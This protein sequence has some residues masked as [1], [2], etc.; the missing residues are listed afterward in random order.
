MSVS[1]PARLWSALRAALVLGVFA[2]AMP[3]AAMEASTNKSD[4]GSVE[5]TGAKTDIV[6]AAAHNVHVA[7]TSSDDV[8]VAGHDLRFDAGSADHVFAAG[9]TI[10][11]TG[12]NARAFL[13]AGHDITF[14]TGSAAS[15]VI[16]FGNN[17]TLNP[18][19]K[20]G[21]S[22]VVFGQDVHLQSPVGRDLTIGGGTVTIDSAITGNVRAQGRH[23]IIGPN[24]RIGGDLSYRAT[25]K[26]EI[27]PTAVITGKKVVLPAD[28]N[29][30]TWGETRHGH[31]VMAG[32]GM[33]HRIMHDVMG[34]L[35][36][37]VLSLVLTAVFPLLMARAGGMLTR[38]PLLAAG[39]GLMVLIVGPVLSILAMVTIIGLSLAFAMWAL[40]WAALLIGFVGAAA[41]IAALAGRYGKNDAPPKLGTQ[42]LWT[43]LGA[44]VI[45]ALGATPYIGFWV[46]LVACVLGTGAVSA[47]A[48]SLMAKGA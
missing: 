1:K 34:A 39:V 8:F 32:G 25:D 29:S 11:V 6:F 16:A 44:I 46:W 31:M 4:N 35:G 41:G 45:S 5:V 37:I 18:T 28:K 13:T 47:Q 20:I 26:I 43:L 15:D 7:A 48:R 42:L 36:F 22:A 9:N 10:S 33:H 12:D 14:D 24:A 3:A 2:L 19:F 17:V 30:I 27:S 40:I 38:N 21:G 23:I